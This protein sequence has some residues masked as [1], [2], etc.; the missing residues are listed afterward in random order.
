MQ[1]TT[2]VAP[3]VITRAMQKTDRLRALLTSSEL[4]FL[5]E[6]HNGLSAK[7][8]EEVEFQG[9]WAS[10][11]AISAS[12]GVRDNNEASWTQ[13]L[14]V[15]EFMSDAT[16]IPILVDGDTGHGNFNNVRRFVQKLEQRGIAGVCIEDKLF[17]KTNSFIHGERQPLADVEEFC[18]RIKAGKDAQADSSFC[19]VARVEALIAGWGLAEALRRAEAYRRAGADAILIHSKRSDASEI[20]TFAREWANRL[21]LAIVPTKYYRTPTELY[22]QHRISAVI[23]A[24]HALRAAIVAMRRVAETIHR[25]ESL[26]SVEE[27]VAPL[28]EVFRLQGM[29]EYLSAEE[30]YLRSTATARPS[31]LILAASRGEELRELTVDRP[32]AMVAIAGR[33][34]LDRFVECLRSEGVQDVTIVAGY[35]AE[36]IQIPG[37][38]IITNAHY[39]GTLDFSS[40]ACA[41][42]AVT[43]DTIIAYGDLLVRRSIIRDLL[44]CDEP[45]VIV[46]DSQVEERIRRGGRGDY[47]ACT[48]PDDFGVSSGVDLPR[49]TGVAV[50]G[51]PATLPSVHGQWVGLL[52]VRGDGVRW[53]RE[54]VDQLRTAENTAR[55]S[56]TDVLNALVRAGHPPAALYTSGNW[57]DVNQL[58]DIERA[59]QFARDIIL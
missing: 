38:R 53:L 29:D 18:G 46:V 56:V 57:T 14:E 1:P 30:R 45:L 52:R 51:N 21:P 3:T 50:G 15:L 31:V 44:K 11:L 36:T 49:L 40:L 28:D 8:A 37:S 12:L 13:V 25:E 58:V 59:S 34:I 33:P 35:H 55:F 39:E 47:V 27:A 23:W 48:A 9:I 32:K 19:I 20:L 42:D 43:S 24:N 4:T 6:A 26:M 16:R 7:I 5:M 22:R 54:A 17:P 10:G 41:M 2:K